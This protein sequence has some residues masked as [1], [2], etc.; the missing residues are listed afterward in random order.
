MTIS[1]NKHL[2]FSCP[3]VAPTQ[4]FCSPGINNDKIGHPYHVF[5]S[6]SFNLSSRNG[7]I[8][9]ILIAHCNGLLELQ[10]FVVQKLLITQGLGYFIQGAV[11]CY[12]YF[13]QHITEERSIPIFIS[14]YHMIISSLYILVL[15]A[16]IYCLSLG[17][18]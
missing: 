17:L 7:L 13:I 2:S 1:K 14:T 8:Q 15:R 3:K 12:G 10:L 18:S 4:A 5:R 6:V 9:L 16:Q 11:N